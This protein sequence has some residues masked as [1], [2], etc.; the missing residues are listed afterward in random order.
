MKN[1]F[2]NV[3]QVLTRSIIKDESVPVRIQHQSFIGTK[4]TLRTFRNTCICV[5][6]TRMYAGKLFD[7]NIIK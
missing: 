1:H 3:H 5:N 7:N 6:R 2:K 4:H